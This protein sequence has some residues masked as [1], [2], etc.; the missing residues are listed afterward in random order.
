MQ[1]I[2]MTSSRAQISEPMIAAVMIDTC[3]INKYYL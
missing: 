2:A 1:P 3:G